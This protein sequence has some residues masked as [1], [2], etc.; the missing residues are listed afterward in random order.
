MNEMQ[1]LRPPGPGCDSSKGFTLVEV[2]VTV[3]IIGILAGIGGLGIMNVLPKMR[4]NAAARDL[5]SDFQ[6]ARMQ[7]VKNNARCTVVFHQSVNGT[8]RDYVVFV[9]N[10]T[11]NLEYDAGEEVLLTQD[12]GT[13]G[14]GVGL[15]TSMGG[16]DGTSI[17]DNGDGNPALGYTSRGYTVNTA[18]GTVFLNNANGDQRTVMVNLT[19][20]IRID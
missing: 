20:Q 15:D 5:R 2:M 9:D 8:I 11:E 1:T 17:A 3:A 4:L 13:Y 10:S 18:N 19:G 12:F 16:G 14:S 7:A 6:Q